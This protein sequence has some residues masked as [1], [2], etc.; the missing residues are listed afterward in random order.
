MQLGWTGLNKYWI[1]GNIRTWQETCIFK[2]L[3]LTEHLPTPNSVQMV[4]WLLTSVYVLR[5]GQVL[6]MY[7]VPILRQVLPYFENVMNFEEMFLYCLLILL[8]HCTFTSLTKSNLFAPLIAHFLRG[9]GWGETRP[10]GETCSLS[11][12]GVT[13][14]DR[15]EWVG[16]GGVYMCS[17]GFLLVLSSRDGRAGFAKSHLMSQ[18]DQSRKTLLKWWGPSCSFCARAILHGRNHSLSSRHEWHMC[19]SLRPFLS[20]RIW[21]SRYI[22][23]NKE[24]TSSAPLIKTNFMKTCG[25]GG[26]GGERAP[27]VYISAL[28]GGEFLRVCPGGFTPG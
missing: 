12:R 14:A 6:S 1:F 21:H 19:T 7:M 27:R 15:D 10:S 8:C 3:V 9:R 23:V 28:D 5:I 4:S 13:V 11:A 26:E 2:P 16:R 18:I 17:P 20:L 24:L 25:R 22:Q